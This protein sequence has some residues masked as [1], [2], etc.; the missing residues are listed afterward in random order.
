M[1]NLDTCILAS[2]IG[3]SFSL[4]PHWNYNA[5]KLTRLYGRLTDFVD[6]PEDT[7]HSN[8]VSGDFTHYGDQTLW[9]LDHISRKRQFDIDSFRF[10]WE[11]A[12]RGYD[13]YFDGASQ[14]T[15]SN[16]RD[17]MR[18]TPSTSNDLAGASRIAPLLLAENL[19]DEADLVWAAREQTRMT[20]GD[21]QVIDSAEFFMRVTVRVLAGEEVLP[22]LRAV[23]SR[24][25]EALP[26]KEWSQ[27]AES[28]LKT[29]TTNAIVKLGQ[30]CHV[31]HAFPATL[32]LLKKYSHSLEEA[33][34]ENAMAGG[35]SAA[36]GMLLGM[37]LGASLGREAIP[38]RWVQATKEA[39]S[40]QEQIHSLL[41]VH[42]FGTLKFDFKNRAGVRLSGRLEQP[43][44][45]PKGMALFAHCFTCS[46]EIAAAS[47]ITREMARKGF[48]VLRFD[49]TGLGN[50]DGDFA[51]TGFSA[52]VEDLLDAA[53]A[54]EAHVRQPVTLLVGH[55]LG[56]A[57][58]L[59]AATKLPHLKGVATIGAP[60]DP[61][62][63]VHLF[64]DA[65]PE[66]K[67]N[68]KADITLAG[69]PFTISNSLVEDLTRGDHVQTL[70]R[71]A[72]P[73]LLLHAPEDQTVGVEHADYLEERLSGPVS[74]MLLEG[75]NHLLTRNEDA[76][77]TAQII[78]L[79]SMRH[80]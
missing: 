19:K 3:D 58:V 75:A 63:V 15:L 76:E 1:D 41:P 50:S 70:S 34:I 20:H 21:D 39:S 57:A 67:A 4:A 45:P 27:K 49:F 37:V 38:E 55:S 62:H 6:L 77:F 69:R 59:S 51:N 48:M 73:V 25:F 80:E 18:R 56:G 10:Q 2:F 23:A 61:G 79:W 53:A 33:L 32:Y 14:D 47:R 78:S 13:G 54:L 17:G 5:S 12:M 29:D 40:I 8:R 44:G 28:L 31:D 72:L 71:L 74:K 65:L 42:R 7:Y 22:A 60:A 43:E 9:L 46:K 16:L 36:R 68:G 64:Q 52:N 35:D 30:T 24:S 26:A 66:V 11:E